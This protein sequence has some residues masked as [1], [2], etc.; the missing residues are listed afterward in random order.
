MIYLSLIKNYKLFENWFQQ[1]KLKSILRIYVRS[2]K[3][4]DRLSL[5]D[6]FDLDIRTYI[7]NVWPS[8][9]IDMWDNTG[10][11]MGNNMG[12]FLYSKSQHHIVKHKSMYISLYK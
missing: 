9:R 10:E 4:E 6:F 5:R 2:Y 12:V 3:I 7:C 1:Q 11:T 8:F